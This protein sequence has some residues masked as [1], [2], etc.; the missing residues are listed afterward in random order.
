MADKLVGYAPYLV[1]YLAEAGLLGFLLYRGRGKRLL[2]LCGYVLAFLLADAGRYYT[3]YHYG[4]AS[5]QYFYF[6]WLSDVALTIAAF[7]LIWSF[8]KRACS[9]EERLRLI[10]RRVLPSVFGLVVLVSFLSILRHYSHLYSRFIVDFSQNLYFTCLILNT[11]LYILMQHIESADEE[12]GFLVLGMGI[13]YAPAAAN[14]ALI[15]LTP[16]R[17]GFGALYHYLGPFS[18]LGMLLVWYYGT[19]RTPKGAGTSFPRI[20]GD[21]LPPLAL[22]G[23]R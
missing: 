19:V 7:A 17:Q 4:Q 3:L 10:V 1:V 21:G 13:Q 11:V 23:I 12:L 9:K 8:F 22:R 2:G 20:G 15:Y 5:R 16:G 14:F 18:T 6:Y